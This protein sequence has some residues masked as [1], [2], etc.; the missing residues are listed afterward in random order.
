MAWATSRQPF[1]MLDFLRF[2]RMCPRFAKTESS[3][4]FLSSQLGGCFNDRSQRITVLAGVF[5]ISV[6]NAPKLVTRFRVHSRR[7]VHAAIEHDAASPKARIAHLLAARCVVTPTARLFSAERI[8]NSR[9]NVAP[10]PLTITVDIQGT[11]HVLGRKRPAMQTESVAVL[12]GG[13]T[14]D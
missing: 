4:E 7:R 1:R 3:C 2:Y 6:V 11:A 5:T 14:V 10:L 13:K 12:F 9:V 8:G